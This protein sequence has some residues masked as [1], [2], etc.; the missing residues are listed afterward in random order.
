M[1]ARSVGRVLDNII[2]DL[3]AF[4]HVFRANLRGKC[5]GEVSDGSQ[6]RFKLLD[7][8]GSKTF[9]MNQTIETLRC[10]V[11]SLSNKRGVITITVRV[12]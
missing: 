2:G 8:E 7:M 10:A 6:C 11:R 4:H 3:I 12:G 1:S 9:E 5:E